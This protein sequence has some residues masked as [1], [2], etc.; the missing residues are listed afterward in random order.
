MLIADAKSQMLQGASTKEF[1]M[2]RL[3]PNPSEPREPSQQCQP[4]VP[5]SQPFSTPPW[6]NVVVAALSLRLCRQAW[7]AWRLFAN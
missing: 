2:V 5:A 3:F 1:T 7:R 6:A 4:A